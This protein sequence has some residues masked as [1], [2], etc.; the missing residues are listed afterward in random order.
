MKLLLLLVVVVVV[1]V[2][3]AAVVVEVVIVI[4]VEI[5]ALRSFTLRNGD[6]F[7]M[8]PMPRRFPSLFRILG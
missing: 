6:D 7:F 1:V 2:V 3:V 5:Y 4:V 8:L